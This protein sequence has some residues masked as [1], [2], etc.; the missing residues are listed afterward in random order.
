MA[1]D[2]G[3]SPVYK[4]SLEGK[5]VA[6]KQLKF[7]SPLHASTLIAAYDGTFDLTH[8]NIVKVLGICP[9]QRQIV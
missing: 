7:Y 8:Y 5:I 1:G 2:G 4:G 3:L 9:K 6:A